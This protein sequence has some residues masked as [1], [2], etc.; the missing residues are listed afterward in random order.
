MMTAFTISELLDNEQFIVAAIEIE[1]SVRREGFRDGWG[2]IS[3]SKLVRLCKEYISEN[4]DGQETIEGDLKGR[5]ANT[6][7]EQYLKRMD[8]IRKAIVFY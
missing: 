3:R 2:D 6:P 1:R 4:V 8:T 7:L 5:L